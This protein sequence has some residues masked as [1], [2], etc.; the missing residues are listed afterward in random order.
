[1]AASILVDGWKPVTENES[2]I[3]GVLEGS[4]LERTTK[5]GLDHFYQ[6]CRSLEKAGIQLKYLRALDNFDSLE[7][8][9]YK[10][11]EAEFA[12]VHR[13]WFRKYTDLYSEDNRQAILRGQQVNSNTL[14][15]C[16]VQREAFKKELLNIAE[17]HNL[18]AFLAPAATG[19][20]PEGLESTGDCVMNLPWT[21]AGM[22]VVT[23]PSGFSK[24][25][26]PMGLQIVGPWMEDE[27]L[28][29]MAG[30]LAG[31]LEWPV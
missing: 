10:M 17:Q 27:R 28:L 30:H 1:M 15:R 8:C 31:H 9:H 12:V 11:C 5:E 20:A 16:R 4:Y 14:K 6:T 13:N 18:S 26:L 29:D 24:N 3:C 7:N 22:P 25:G 21:L 19:P 23:L 2:F